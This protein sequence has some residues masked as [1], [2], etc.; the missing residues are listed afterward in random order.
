MRRQHSCERSSFCDRIVETAVERPELY[1]DE[2]LLGGRTNRNSP[3]SQAL[4]PSAKPSPR[5]VSTS[6]LA[7]ELVQPLAGGNYPAIKKTHVKTPETM[8]PTLNAKVAPRDALSVAPQ[9][10]TLLAR[11]RDKAPFDR[12]GVQL[13]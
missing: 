3:R 4:R 10:E 12:G 6:R 13:T 8:K 9:D 2:R 5:S 7:S 1:A 11:G